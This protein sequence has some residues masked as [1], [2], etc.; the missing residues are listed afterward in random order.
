M[1]ACVHGC[2]RVCAVAC[3]RDGCVRVRVCGCVHTCAR[4]WLRACVR[5]CLRACVRVYVLP[6][7]ARPS[8]L[9]NY[10]ETQR[11]AYYDI[12]ICTAHSLQFPLYDTILI[13]Y[14]TLTAVPTVRYPTFLCYRLCTAQHSIL[15]ASFRTTRQ[16][17]ILS[18]RACMILCE[19][20]WLRARVWVCVYLNSQNYIKTQR[21]RYYDIF[22]SYRT[23]LYVMFLYT[24]YPIRSTVKF[25]DPARGSVRRLGYFYSGF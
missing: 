15:Y 7:C 17:Y 9:Q 4:S 6:A 13:F 21:S 24:M 23:L 8:N 18:V 11:G 3:A 2:V 16:N 25:L 14:R 20:V 10:T 5:A 12:F 22:Y 19:R 1:R